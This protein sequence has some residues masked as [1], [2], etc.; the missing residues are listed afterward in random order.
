MPA[1]KYGKIEQKI[2]DRYNAGISRQQVMVEFKL[3]NNQMAGLSNRLG[4]VWSR[5][6]KPLH[7]AR[8]F[9]EKPEPKSPAKVAMP[10]QKK[11]GKPKQNAPGV[12]QGTAALSAEIDQKFVEST[13]D[14]RRRMGTPPMMS[15]RERRER[16]FED[17][18]LPAHM[19][20]PGDGLTTEDIRFLDR[21][22]YRDKK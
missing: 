1:H 12:E 6:P 11:S 13:R 7:V 15:S 18:E 22:L 19:P 9:V 16:G 20:K 21:M 8:A 17:L 5:Q 14:L 10:P 3:E 4:L 2:R